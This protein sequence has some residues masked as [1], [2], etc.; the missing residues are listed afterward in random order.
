MTA[1]LIILAIWVAFVW[2]YDPDDFG[3]RDRAAARVGLPVSD[4]VVI[5]VKSLPSVNEK[6][7]K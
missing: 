1:T 5:D 2:F 4:P 3:R 6:Y 7:T